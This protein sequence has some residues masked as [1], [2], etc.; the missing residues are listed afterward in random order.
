MAILFLLICLFAPILVYGTEATLLFYIAL[1]NTILYL[2]TLFAIPNIIAYSAMKKH[3]TRVEEA[4][5]QGATK[6]VMES[7]LNDDLEILEEDH[8]AAPKWLY[9]ISFVNVLL[10]VIFCVWGVFQ[11]F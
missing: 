4:Y 2:I 10:A 7:I 3:K 11:I 5:Q 9:Y 6:E 1:A 8:Q